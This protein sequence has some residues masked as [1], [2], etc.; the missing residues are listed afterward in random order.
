MIGV[1]YFCRIN[2]GRLAR[3]NICGCANQSGVVRIKYRMCFVCTIERRNY[4]SLDGAIGHEEARSVECF[5]YLI[6]R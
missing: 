1:V 4:I 5:G 2:G 3:I 6:F